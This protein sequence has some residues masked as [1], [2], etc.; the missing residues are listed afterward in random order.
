MLSPTLY[1][2]YYNCIHFLLPGSFKTWTP[3]CLAP[4]VL[5]QVMFFF[6]LSVYDTRMYDMFIYVSMLWHMCMGQ[7]TTLGVG[8]CFCCIWDIVSFLVCQCRLQV[9]GPMGM[10]RLYSLPLIGS[11]GLIDPLHQT[12]LCV[13]MGMWTQAPHLHSKHLT[14]SAVF[15]PWDWPFVSSFDNSQMVVRDQLYNGGW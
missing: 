5:F 2:S 3:L 11:A 12:Q 14:C 10:Q 4:W 15:P 6:T 9:A 13:I 7:R 1:P 8:T